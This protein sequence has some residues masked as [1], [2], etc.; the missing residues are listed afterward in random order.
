LKKMNGSLA[1]GCCLAILNAGPQ[2]KLTQPAPAHVHVSPKAVVPVAHVELAEDHS[3]APAPHFDSTGDGFAIEFEFSQP[4]SCHDADVFLPAPPAESEPSGP[5]HSPLTSAPIWQLRLPMLNI[6]PT[7]GC[8][9]A[10]SLSPPAE[11]SPASDRVQH[12]RQAMQHLHAAGMPELARHAGDAYVAA[13]QQRREQLQWELQ[14]T[15]QELKRATAELAR[16]SAAPQW[17]S[18]PPHDSSRPFSPLSTPPQAPGSQIAPSSNTTPA[19]PEPMSA[20]PRTPTLLKLINPSFYVGEAPPRVV[21]AWQQAFV[22]DSQPANAPAPVPALPLRRIEGAGQRFRLLV[23]A[24]QPN[25]GSPRL[26]YPAAPALPESKF[27]LPPA[28]LPETH[29]ES[30]TEPVA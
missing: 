6:Q 13:L 23:P 4:E 17:T 10:S 16:S 15:T 3:P 2:L 9:E 18:E 29:V 12:L 27:E 8:D 7:A 21:D 28:P 26:I 19:A 20:A 1:L 14:Q 24:P 5:R 22:P 25:L 30:E 11:L